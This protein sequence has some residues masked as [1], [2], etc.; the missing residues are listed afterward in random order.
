MFLYAFVIF[1]DKDMTWYGD[2]LK[3]SWIF[4][5]LSKVLDSGAPLWHLAASRSHRG[6]FPRPHLRC[7]WAA[8]AQLAE[9]QFILP[10]MVCLIPKSV[11]IQGLPGASR[12]RGWWV[13]DFLDF[14][15]LSLDLFGIS[16][17]FSRFSALWPYI[18][19]QK[20]RPVGH[21]LL[22]IFWT[23]FDAGIFLQCGVTCVSWSTLQ[24]RR[25]SRLDSSQEWCW[26]VGPIRARLVQSPLEC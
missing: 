24:H 1:L 15:V 17:L 10:E 23:A 18:S 2:R 16:V 21:G 7:N 11:T 5:T 20:A 6:Q 12:A 4:D 9:L 19:S 3:T 13:L 8:V 26:P 14:W 22:R 25:N